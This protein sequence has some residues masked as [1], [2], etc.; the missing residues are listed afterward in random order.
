[1]N[2]ERDLPLLGLFCAPSKLCS[3]NVQLPQLT[4][5]VTTG[6]NPAEQRTRDEHEILDSDV[7]RQCVCTGHQGAT[8]AA[9]VPI[10][11]RNPRQQ[12][13]ATAPWL[14]ASFCKN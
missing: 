7:S 11:A 10:R 6:D 2:K 14:S 3:F 12:R 13:E 1:M 5:E 9:S 4:D 8:A